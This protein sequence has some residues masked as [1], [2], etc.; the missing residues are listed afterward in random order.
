MTPSEL[1]EVRSQHGELPTAPLTEVCL[2]LIPGLG[3]EVRTDRCEGDVPLLEIIVGHARLLI[4]FDVADV[5]QLGAE[6]L[7]LAEQ[8]AQAAAALRDETRRLVA[9]R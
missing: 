2:S 3:L 1:A 6:H 7:E 9:G 8:F 5:R 4:T